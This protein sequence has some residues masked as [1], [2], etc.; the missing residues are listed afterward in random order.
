MTAAPTGMNNTTPRLWSH[1]YKQG[2]AASRRA[3][4]EHGADADMDA[5]LARFTSRTDAA[6]AATVTDAYITGWNDQAVGNDYDTDPH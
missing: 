2:W 3:D 6:V 4:R 1:A 5:A